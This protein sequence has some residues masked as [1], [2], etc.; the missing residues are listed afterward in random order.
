MLRFRVAPIY[1][2]YL[3]PN[4]RKLQGYF[5][6]YDFDREEFEFALQIHDTNFEKAVLC[7]GILVG[8][9]MVY[10]AVAYLRTRVRDK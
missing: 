5:H 9:G 8:L 4:P 3:S 1:W 10:T 7:I 2:E 6:Y